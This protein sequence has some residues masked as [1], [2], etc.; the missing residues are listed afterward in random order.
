MLRTTVCARVCPAVRTRPCS[1]SESPRPAGNRGRRQ[2]CALERDDDE[3][4]GEGGLRQCVEHSTDHKDR[5]DVYRIR[6]QAGAHLTASCRADPMRDI[7]CMAD[8]V[9]FTHYAVFVII[10]HATVKESSR[11]RRFDI[12]LGRGSRPAR[13]GRDLSAPEEGG[14]PEGRRGPPPRRTDHFEP[15]R[16][17]CMTNRPGF[18]RPSRRVLSSRSCRR[19]PASDPDRIPPPRDRPPGAARGLLRTYYVHVH[20]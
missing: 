13:G 19:P 6:P 7:T 18:A 9:Y 10:E 8:H 20:Y 16:P 1:D 11:F 3:G 15:R 12:T 17:I 5:V 2:V 14:G 4:C